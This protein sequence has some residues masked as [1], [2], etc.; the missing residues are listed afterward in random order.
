MGRVLEAVNIFAL[1]DEAA[2]DDILTGIAI[3]PNLAT[4]AN[5]HE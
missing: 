4:P 3:D 1:A 5:A 2:V